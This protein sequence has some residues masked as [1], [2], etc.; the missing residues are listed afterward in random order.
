MRMLAPPP[1]DGVMSPLRGPSFRRPHDTGVAALVSPADIPRPVQ[2]TATGPDDGDGDVRP[3]TPPSGR[4]DASRWPRLPAAPLVDAVSHR[5]GLRELLAG[6]RK[7]REGQRL[8]RSY[9]RA[10][11]QGWV[12]VTTADVLACRLLG[13][14]PCFLWGETF[15]T[16]AG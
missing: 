2:V 12:T 3:P 5:G 14:H 10:K 13:M 11:A 6:R 8:A 9:F 15:W 16:E 1:D 7:T 4:S